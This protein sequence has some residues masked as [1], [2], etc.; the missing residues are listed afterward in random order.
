MAG[1]GIQVNA[2]NPGLIKIK[3]YAAGGAPD[4]VGRLAAMGVVKR[5]RGRRRVLRHRCPGP[6][7]R[8]PLGHFYVDRNRPQPAPPPGH[9]MLLYAVGGPVGER[10]GAGQS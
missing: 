6:C 4:C 1:E 2:A 7:L 9:P 10:A 5:K 8:R 3:I